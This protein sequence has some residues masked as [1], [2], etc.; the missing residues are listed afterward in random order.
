MKFGLK[1]WSTNTELL[2]QAIQ[3]IDKKIFD[4]IELFIVPNTQISP[5][6]IDILYVIH[7]PHEK[8]GVNIGDCS[9]KKY[10]LQKIKESITWADKLNAQY[11]I[12]HAGYGSVENAIDIL[13]EVEDN[14]LLIENVP[15]IGLNNETMIGYLPAQIEKLIGDND[16]GL[17]LDLNHAAKA[18]VSLGVDYQ[19]FI[20]D[21]LIF[22]PK[23]FHISDGMLSNEKDEHLNIGEGDYDIE[24]LMNCVNRS[25]LGYV[26]LET[27]RTK[28]S[29]LEEDLENC[30]KLI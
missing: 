16:I 30:G 21:F 9:K 28:L 19:E 18:A 23:M 11:L 13:H 15:K 4:Y 8:F 10:N 27:P 5:F 17:C 24:F 7:I 26:T 29:S 12:L 22:D 25:E 1:L 2:N 6:I 14:R 20:Q 3:L